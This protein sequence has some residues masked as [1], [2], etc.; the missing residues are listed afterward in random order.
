MRLYWKQK[1]Q[2][3][4]L[5]ILRTYK[6]DPSKGRMKRLLKVVWP[7]L[8]LE[9]AYTRWRSPVWEKT[10]KEKGFSHFIPKPHSRCFD[11][12]CKQPDTLKEIFQEIMKFPHNLQAGFASVA[13]LLKKSGMDVTHGTIYNAWYNKRSKLYQYRIKNTD[14]VLAAG[15]RVVLFHYKN[16]RRNNKGEIPESSH[17]C[18]N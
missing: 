4:V 12:L 11:N 17:L 5:A 1:E 6:D 15:G 2:E 3:R 14:D 18:E 13:E 10:L 9:Q 7:D 8:S 16:L